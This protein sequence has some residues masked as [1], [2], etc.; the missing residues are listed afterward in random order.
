[1][2]TATFPPIA[3]RPDNLAA[4]TRS[5]SPA[6][7]MQKRARATARSAPVLNRGGHQIELRN[8]PAL[9]FA[10]KGRYPRTA[11]EFAEEGV[12][13]LCCESCNHRQALNP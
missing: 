4:S 1:M 11:F 5:R 12:V 10:V 7:A 3:V 6:A 2:P 9:R 8:A 13:I